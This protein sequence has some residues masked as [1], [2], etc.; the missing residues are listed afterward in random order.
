MP[1]PQPESAATALVHEEDAV[2]LAGAGALTQI[3]GVAAGV[4]PARKKR[5]GIGAWLC[6][7]WLVGLFVAAVAAPILPIPGPN[8]TF[9]SIQRAQ[10]PFATIDQ[11]GGGTTTPFAEG[12]YLGGDRNG[13]DLLS[14]AV[15]GARNSLIVG[16]GAIAFGI[17]VGASL[18]LIAGYYGG[19]ARH[20]A[21]RVLR[22]HAGHTRAR[23]RALVD[24]RAPRSHCRP[25][26]PLSSRS[27][28]SP[29]RSSDGSRAPT[30]SCGRG[31][32]SSPP[33]GHRARRTGAS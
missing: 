3:A 20:R 30:P 19:K 29:Y 14:R 15:Y 24:R 32:S 33:P 23:A 22:R 9:T 18:G 1:E 8:E 4:E 17:A 16:F 11:P 6:I 31:G 7:A 10:A 13:H 12:H 27:A 2:G 26:D 21:R 28:S 5:L 25:V